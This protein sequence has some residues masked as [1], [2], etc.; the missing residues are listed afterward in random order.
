MELE[1][2]G[3]DFARLEQIILTVQKEARN[4][5]GF[6]EPDTSVRQGKPELRITPRRAILAD[7]GASPYDLGL[8]LR[9]NL[10]G[11][12]AT[13]YKSG[14]EFLQAGIMAM[15]PDHPDP[16]FPVHQKNRERL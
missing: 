8:M 4:M 13:S 7:L 10:E 9:A 6:M 5:A 3:T 1:V 11:I 15:P 2:S 16:V 14:E 12:K